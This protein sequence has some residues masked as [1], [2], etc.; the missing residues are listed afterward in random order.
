M[1]NELR[2]IPVSGFM[3]VCAD[4]T[5]GIITDN[6][7]EPISDLICILLSIECGILD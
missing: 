3:M 6:I 2:V 4:T 1:A 7:T 5:Q